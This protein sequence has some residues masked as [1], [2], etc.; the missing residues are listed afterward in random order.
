MTWESEALAVLELL[1][2]L[3]LD[4]HTKIFMALLV[5]AAWIDVK[6]NRIP[7]LSLRAAHTRALP[8]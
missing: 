1:K 2:I 3:V 7:N 5:V 4:P 6:T 8:R